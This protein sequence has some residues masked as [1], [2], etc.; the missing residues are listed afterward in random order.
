MTKIG[1]GSLDP[2]SI[3]EILLISK[4]AGKVLTRSVNRFIKEND[5]NHN[6]DLPEDTARFL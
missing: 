6:Y 4:K 3:R 1:I 2:E 5:Q